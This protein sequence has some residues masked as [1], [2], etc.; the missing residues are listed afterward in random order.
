MAL[1]VGAICFVA[2]LVRI[3][4]LA[5]L[6]SRPVLVGYMTGVAVIMIGSQLGKITGVSVRGRRI[7]RPDSVV[8]Q[9]ARRR[10]LADG[11]A[12]RPAVLGVLLALA[13]L[14][15]RCPGPLIAM[16][17]ATAVVAMFSLDRNGIRVIGEIPS[18]LPTPGLPGVDLADLSALLIPPAGIAIV[19]SPTMC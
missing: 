19:G 14:A 11:R 10:A 3:G 7:R 9:R 6:L 18:G 13:R 2:G 1:L 5:D 12:W 15:P 16:L 8:R 4:F 17:L